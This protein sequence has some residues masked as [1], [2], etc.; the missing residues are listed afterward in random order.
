MSR[1][2]LASI[3]SDSSFHD[4]CGPIASQF[5]YTYQKYSNVDDFAEK[6]EGSQYVCLFLSCL[7]TNSGSEIAGRIQAVRQFCGEAFIVC[8]IS[9][10]LDSETAKFAK[11]SG[12]NLILFEN[13]F[14]STIQPE[15]ICSQIIRGSLIPIK[16][17]D[18]RPNTKVDFTIRYLMPLNKKILPIVKAGTTLTDNQITKLKTAT[19]LYVSREDLP[20]YEKY[21]MENPDN[22]AQG[23]NSRCRIK[24]LLLGKSHAELIYLLIDQAESASFEVG[25]KLYDRC[26]QLAGELLNILATV[27]NP[28]AIVNNSSFG[29]LGSIERSSSVAAFAGLIS[30]MLGTNKE[31]ETV[32][33]GLLCDLGLLEI[34]PQVSAAL[35][36]KNL[37]ILNPDELKIYHQHP[38]TSLNMCLAKKFPVPE[39]LKKIIQRTH[40]RADGK[41]FPG[42]LNSQVIPFESMLIQYCEV[43]DQ[44]LI[45]KIGEAK[46][47]VMEL[48]KEIINKSLEGSSQ[49]SVELVSKVSSLLKS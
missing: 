48:Q 12:A 35:K 25:K 23:L 38:N 30:L 9:K 44:A 24:Y 17:F 14:S 1:I 29:E 6:S 15:Y 47:D 46:I 3:S 16:A 4:R 34:T 5:E 8:I 26:I 33:A 49:F 21:I 36:T 42:A 10:K 37:S 13:Q 19:E 41:G 2:H 11:K 39:T 45:P 32:T 20:Q 31:I 7:D 40:E 22:S 28:W 43:L 18:L 27:E